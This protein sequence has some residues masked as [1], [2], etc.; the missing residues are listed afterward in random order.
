[1][2]QISD[3][4]GHMHHGATSHFGYGSV[5]HRGHGSTPHRGHGSMSY[6]GHESMPHRGH[7]SM[8][9]RGHE[10]M[11]HRGSMFQKSLPR[12]LDELLTKLK[13]DLQQQLSTMKMIPP[14][15]EHTIT[16]DPE[17][18]LTAVIHISVNVRVPYIDSVVSVIQVTVN[19]DGSIDLS[20]PAGITRRFTSMNEFDFV[21]TFVRRLRAHQFN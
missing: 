4:P 7:G 20:D 11:S 21:P 19:K 8:S 9:H 16:G 10:S 2:S 12:Q 6:R 15:V 14:T 17:T 13:K 18:R 5:P 1:M 3:V